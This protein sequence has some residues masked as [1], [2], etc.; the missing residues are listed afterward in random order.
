MDFRPNLYDNNSL[1]MLN[2]AIE[3]NYRMG[4]DARRGALDLMRMESDLA[5][6]EMERELAPMELEIQLMKEK[7]QLAMQERGM[8]LQQQQA[9][10]DTIQTASRLLQD[11]TS[12]RLAAAN[13]RQGVAERHLQ[14]Y[15][16]TLEKSQTAAVNQ[17]AAAEAW[18][19]ASAD[20]SMAMQGVLAAYSS[21]VER[22][23][24]T[25]AITGVKKLVPSLE[26]LYG[27]E[28]DKKFGGP[29]VDR[30]GF[31][32]AFADEAVERARNL[33]AAQ[34]GLQFEDAYK[35][36]VQDIMLLR[37]AS[38][39]QR[40][41]EFGAK[42]ASRAYLEAVKS[43]SGV[44]AAKERL[45]RQITIGRDGG[46]SFTPRQEY[47]GY[48]P[49]SS[50]GDIAWGEG[51]EGGGD[52]LLGSVGATAKDVLPSPVYNNMAKFEVMVSLIGGRMQ[53]HPAQNYLSKAD[54]LAVAGRALTEAT[55][56]RETVGASLE[57]LEGGRKA[58]LDELMS[59]GVEI[60]RIARESEDG[61]NVLREIQKRNIGGKTHYNERVTRDLRVRHAEVDTS[62]ADP[63]VKAIFSKY[64]DTI[65]DEFVQQGHSQEDAERLG[66]IFSGLV[67]QESAGDPNA[68]SSA[69]AVG[70]TQLMPATADEVGID[71]RDRTDPEKSLRGGVR[72][73]NK[74]LKLND[75][76]LALALS[77][78]NGGPR[79]TRRSGGVY[80]AE[81]TV[82]YIDR[83]L[84]YFGY[85]DKK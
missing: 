65:V 2:Q 16:R 38:I 54:G 41:A 20:K 48:S 79:N 33:M 75:G 76:D 35:S 31:A 13:A 63:K 3:S 66:M 46:W 29:S 61:M 1:A 6:R 24:E 84:G 52:V 57:A 83:I 62:R 42:D 69:G 40:S 45:V 51:P 14:L 15:D 4:A 11:Q 17:A 34:P 85:W 81:E 43:G 5:E 28:S 70:L 10:N 27:L 72:Y 49:S 55:K 21:D 7:A 19:R 58:S 8:N 47:S 77:S 12:N 39:G 82:N 30:A 23:E 9:N 53:A 50:Y 26:R 56:Y 73:F 36:S 32:Q 80:G 18:D 37:I 78:Y 64:G 60:D 67:Y 74:H 44:E 71:P 25:S 59:V 68:R 22:D